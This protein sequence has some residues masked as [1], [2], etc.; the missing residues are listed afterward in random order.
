MFG[1]AGPDEP[2]GPP[3]SSKEAD[4]A[5]ND[6]SGDAKGCGK[7]HRIMPSNARPKMAPIANVIAISLSRIT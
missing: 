6:G 3:A 5:G 7:A 2:G 1:N 4:V